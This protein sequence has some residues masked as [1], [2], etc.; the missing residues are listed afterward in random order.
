MIQ[1]NLLLKGLL[2]AFSVLLVSPDLSAQKTDTIYLDNG[3]RVIGEVKKMKFGIL[4]Y[5]T[6]SMGTVKVE[7]TDV[8]R[9]ISDKRYQ[10]KLEDGTILFGSIDSTALVSQTL[11]LIPGATEQTRLQNLVQITRI[12]KIFWE[13]FDGFINVGYTYNK[14]SEVG[15]LNLDAGLSYRADKYWGNL[16]L[17]STNTQLNAENRT[18]VNESI[19]LQ[20]S[21]IFT[22]F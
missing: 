22:K 3:D 19:S 8:T 9:M 6:Q 2:L 18:T 5:S 15:A 10:V 17:H 11:L 4:E 13:R 12:K 7:W 14:A 20:G 1:T 21:R 16:E